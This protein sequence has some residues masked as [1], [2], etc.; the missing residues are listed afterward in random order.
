MKRIH[1]FGLALGTLPLVTAGTLAACSSSSPG[2]TTTPV[3]SGAANDSGAKSDSAE[4][5]DSTSKAETSPSD[6]SADGAVIVGPGAQLLCTSSGK[7][8]W[9]TYG[10]TGFVAVNKAIFANVTSQLATDAGAAGLGATLGE[11]GTDK[12]PALADPLPAFEGNLAAFLVF[13]YGG[14]TSIKYTDGNTYSGLQDLVTAHKG[15]GITSSQYAYFI[16]NVVVP[17]LTT[18]G[19]KSEDVSSCFAPLVLSTTFMQEVVGNGASSGFDLKCSSGKNAFD[20]YGEAAFVKVNEAI[21][22]AVGK[23]EATDAGVGG[24]GTTF[25]FVGTGA[26]GDATVPALDDSAATF[27]GTLAAFLVWS[28]GGPAEIKYTDGKTYSGIQSLTPEHTGLGITGD[29]YTYFLTNVVE[30][31]LL[32]NGVTMTDLKACFAPV[33]LDPNFEAQVVGH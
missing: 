2:G 4:A 28:L 12:V 14:P 17:A 21:F 5:M 10:A 30:P 33:L 16:T 3:D 11:V 24:L 19:V 32:S 27:K 18:S 1:L 22:T 20:T 13:A 8:A 31:S 15:L 7:N 29:E 6:S 25:Q 23:Q 26:I 9:R